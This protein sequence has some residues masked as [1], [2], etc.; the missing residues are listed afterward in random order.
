MVAKPALTAAETAD[1][2]AILAAMTDRIAELTTE[3]RQLKAGQ[4]RA[5]DLLLHQHLWTKY[6]RSGL[7]AQHSNI[8]SIHV[9][10]IGFKR[11][12]PSA[13]RC[14]FASS[15][16]LHTFFSVFFETPRGKCEAEPA[17]LRGVATFDRNC[18]LRATLPHHSGKR[19]HFST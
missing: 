12:L 15:R 7:T 1:I 8:D 14:C 4:A 3:A 18:W 11:V 6:F 17:S 16:A 10:R 9:R 2:A 5:S 13:P 19:R